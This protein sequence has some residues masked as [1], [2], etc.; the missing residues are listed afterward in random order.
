MYTRKQNVRYL[1]IVILSTIGAVCAAIGISAL[2][3]ACN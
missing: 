2:L 3:Q 1:G